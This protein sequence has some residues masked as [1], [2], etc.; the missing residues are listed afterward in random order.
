MVTNGSRKVDYV[1]IDGDDSLKEVVDI[2]NLSI[3]YSIEE[4]D[5]VTITQDGKGNWIL[6]YWKD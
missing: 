5:V 2:I 1:F 4:K 6:F 3:E